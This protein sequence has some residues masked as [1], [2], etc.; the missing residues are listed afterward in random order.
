MNNILSSLAL[1]LLIKQSIQVHIHFHY[2]IMERIFSSYDW[3]VPWLL[4]QDTICTR[5]FLVRS[6][7]LN[8]SQAACPLYDN[9][10]KNVNHPFLHC[11]EPW[12]LRQRFM[13]WLGISWCMLKSI[14][15]LVL[16][17]SILVKGRF[18]WRAFTMLSYGI[19]WNIWSAR[20][21]LIF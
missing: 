15:Q 5:D 7:L 12:Y 2:T 14:D 6:W 13:N 10:I 9:G 3:N 18:Q 17:W 11:Y 21:K 16:Q 19:S 1:N 4:L 20:N 8:L